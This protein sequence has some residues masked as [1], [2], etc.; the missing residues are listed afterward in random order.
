MSEKENQSLQILE[1]VL[2][3]SNPGPCITQPD[4]LCVSFTA[5]LMFK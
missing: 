4:Q 5:W 2:L 1:L 3:S